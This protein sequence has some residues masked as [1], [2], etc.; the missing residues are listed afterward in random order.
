[1]EDTTLLRIKEVAELLGLSDVRVYQLVN[2]GKIP[3]FKVST[4]SWRIR[5]TDLL[6]YIKKINQ[7]R[8]GI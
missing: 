4:G 5:K 3:A 8:N 6:D 2:E 1:M 7:E